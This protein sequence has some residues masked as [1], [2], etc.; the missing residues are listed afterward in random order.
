MI[1]AP[2]KDVN[3]TLVSICHDVGGAPLIDVVCWTW[4]TRSQGM[5][6]S[7][8]PS[9]IA[10]RPAEKDGLKS[11]LK[12]MVRYSTRSPEKGLDKSVVVNLPKE[13][14]ESIGRSE[15]M[16]ALRAN[17]EAHLKCYSQNNKYYLEVGGQRT[18]SDENSFVPLAIDANFA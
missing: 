11:L 4:I 7:D 16:D 12:G 9:Y 8:R 5:E 13:V 2:T 10:G 15:S 18:F 1:G 14:A 3:C 6:E 17:L